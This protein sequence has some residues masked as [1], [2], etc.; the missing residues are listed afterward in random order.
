M[1]IRT[2]VM[3]L[4]AGVFAATSARAGLGWTLDECRQHYG[5]VQNT[6]Q[7]GARPHYG[8]T[9]KGFAIFVWFLDGKV[10]HIVY[11]KLDSEIDITA[12]EIE[13]LLQANVPNG[14]SWSAATKD[15]EGLIWSAGRII[16]WLLWRAI[17][18]R[19]IHY[20]F[21]QKQ[22]AILQSKNTRK[23]P[24]ACKGE[25]ISLNPAL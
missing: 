18:R 12:A 6:S 2:L 1:N 8:F 11:Q 14:V 16:I 22:I 17:A 24:K 21:G 9:A 7:D 25:P 15:D 20:R 13:I 3:A 5:G 23:M 10:S 19:T 4:A